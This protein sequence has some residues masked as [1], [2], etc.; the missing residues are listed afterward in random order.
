MKV[1]I[2]RDQP[3]DLNGQ[4]VA[5][6]IAE[7]LKK[8]AAFRRVLK[9]K[10]DATRNAGAKGIKIQISKRIGGA[11][12]ARVEKMINARFPAH[13]AGEYQLWP[14]HRCTPYGV[15]G[16]NKVW[17]YQGTYAETDGRPSRQAKQS[18]AARLASAVKGNWRW[19]TAI[20]DCWMPIANLRSSLMAMMPARVKKWRANSNATS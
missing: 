12:I 14:G 20:A 9:Q 17:I 13:A 11:E 5:E 7:Q 8:R 19:T 15:I 4:L 18:A 3:S 6:G 2:G 16:I 1:E 10:A